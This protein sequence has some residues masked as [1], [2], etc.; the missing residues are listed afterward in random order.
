MSRAAAALRMDMHHYLSL[1]VIICHH[2]RKEVKSKPKRPAA[3]ENELRHTGVS[4]P[5][6]IERL[7][8]VRH[9]DRLKLSGRACCCVASSQCLGSPLHVEVK[10]AFDGQDA[11]DSKARKVSSAAEK[12]S[13]L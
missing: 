2:L 4:Y 11:S 8:L 12:E 13:S 6:G 9:V 10:F 5:W 3:R 7:H 1:S